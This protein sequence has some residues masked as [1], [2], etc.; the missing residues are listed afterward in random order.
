MFH[1]QY[2]SKQVSFY[3]TINCYLIIFMSMTLPFNYSLLAHKLRPALTRIFLPPPPTPPVGVTLAAPKASDHEGWRLTCRLWTVWWGQWPVQSPCPLPS[4]PG[5]RS[6]ET[7]CQVHRSVH[8]TTAAAFACSRKD[9]R[10]VNFCGHNLYSLCVSQSRLCVSR[11]E[12]LGTKN[13]CF[14]VVISILS[15]HSLS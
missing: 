8:C 1:W 6:R 3:G 9:Q 15:Y 4:P 5:H 14:F 2:I 13:V 12:V 11:K 7:S 10:T